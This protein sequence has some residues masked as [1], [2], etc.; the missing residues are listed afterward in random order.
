MTAYDVRARASAGR[1]LAPIAR[2]GKGQVVVL[3]RVTVG[4]YDPATGTIPQVIT[5]QTTSGAVFEY[6]SFLRGGLRNEPGSLILAGDKQILI[7]P[8]KADGT[9][10]DP[11][12]QTDDT[13]TLADGSTFTI[14]HNSPL[15]PA[16]TAVI[17]DCNIRGAT[18]P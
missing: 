9:P 11:P 12:P 14:T 2:G 5:S 17:F 15:S 10:L 4:A 16:G 7:S 13:V 6:T 18:P 8:F 3:T 1:A